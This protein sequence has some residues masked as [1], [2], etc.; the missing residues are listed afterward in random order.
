MRDR[1][2]MTLLRIPFLRRRQSVGPCAT[3]EGTV[4]RDEAHMRIHGVLLHRRCATYRQRQ[5]LSG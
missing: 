5:R 4:F 1:D 3:C 2:P